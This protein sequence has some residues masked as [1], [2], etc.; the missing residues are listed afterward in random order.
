MTFLRNFIAIL[1]CKLLVWVSK[2]LG[3][4]GSSGPGAIALKI[5]P[6]ILKTLAKKVKKEI[7]FVCGTNGKTTTNNLIYTLLTNDGNTV[8]CNN[9]GA[10]MLY[11][12][13]CAFIT[14]ASIFGNLNA[15]YAV[16]ECDEAYLRHAVNHIKPSKILITNLFRDQMDRYGEI[17]QTSQFLSEAIEKAPDAT[18][19]LNADDPICVA[20]GKDRKAIYYG[21]SEDTGFEGQ[22][23]NDGR[24]CHIC[25]GEFSYIY[26]HYNQLGCYKC[27]KCG[28]KRPNPNYSATRIDMTE[29]LKFVL[30]YKGMQHKVNVNYRGF[31]N[32]YNIIG[33][34]AAYEACG[35]SMESA[36]KVFGSYKAQLGRMESFDISGTQAVLNLAKN[37][38][39]FNQSIS[40]VCDDKRQK[41]ILFAVNDAPSD[42]MDISWIYDVDF[43]ALQG[44]N[45]NKIY[46]SGTR[47]YDLALRLK[48]AGFENVEITELDKTHIESII[49]SSNGVCYLI[50]N[51]T[52][53][54]GTQD[55]LK[56]LEVK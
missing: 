47:K 42:G 25:G 26:R 31:Y 34:F 41:D 37:P 48:L 27:D 29:G 36:Q 50:V 28:F 33:S 45:I 8:V 4:K 11:G 22:K 51:Y 43:E 9:V 6:T 53:L 35:G 23:T 1:S 44:N 13:A 18:L 3:K 17:E 38:A 10:N 54:F 12:I 7:I 56:E 21:I 55:I 2:L 39:G 24:F 52:A 30:S 20:L 49:S 5:S 40:A 14:K 16:L 46:V 19:I 32:I 15:D